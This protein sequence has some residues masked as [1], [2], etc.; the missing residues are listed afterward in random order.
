MVLHKGEK[1]RKIQRDA[2]RAVFR[3]CIATRI[4]LAI[5]LRGHLSQTVRPALCVFF[6]VDD[7]LVSLGRIQ[8][9][10]GKIRADLR[11]GFGDLVEAFFCLP[12]QAHA[13]VFSCANFQF[14]APLLRFVEFCPFLALSNRHQ[15]FVNGTA[16]LHAQAISHHVLQHGLVRAAQFIRIFH[17][18][19]MP[20]RAPRIG[21]G[22]AVLFERHEQ[23]LPRR[24]QILLQRRDAL[25]R[26]C[27]HLLHSWHD[28]LGQ[29]FI[30]PRQALYHE[31]GIV[32][33][34]THETP[35]WS[36]VSPRPSIYLKKRETNCMSDAPVLGLAPIEVLTPD[37]IISQSL[38]LIHDL[39]HRVQNLV[40]RRKFAVL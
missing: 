12:G 13:R 36:V 26:I 39:A 9:M 31:Q 37:L 3:C 23:T 10:V 1:T 21:K 16:L 28:V 4:G 22:Q 5:G 27:Q 6:V 33:C 34:V 20:D 19:Q 2:P 18:H 11:Q 32:C 14:H 25:F 30:V 8:Y 17:P 40:C 24:G 15:A 38:H 29:N 7:Q 35:P